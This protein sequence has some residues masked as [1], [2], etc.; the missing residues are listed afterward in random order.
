MASGYSAKRFEE[1]RGKRKLCHL[2]PFEFFDHTGSHW[3]YSV[4]HRGLQNWKSWFRAQNGR[5]KGTKLFFL[6]GLQ[7]FW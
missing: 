7:G 4:G 1:N 3:M 5:K 6:D 2:N